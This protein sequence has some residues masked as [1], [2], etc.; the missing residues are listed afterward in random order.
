MYD[1]DDIVDLK[2]RK[3]RQRRMKKLLIIL[4]VAVLL[5]TLFATRSLWIPIV[6]GWGNHYKTIVNSGKLA[7][8]NFPIDVDG[9]EDYQIRYT[10]ERI[11]VQSDNNL[12]IYDIDGR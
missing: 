4:I 7:D 11:M 12:Y 9:G 10:V 2:N 8:G 1:K 3:I 6:K 5:V